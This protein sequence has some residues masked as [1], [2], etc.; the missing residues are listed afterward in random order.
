[1]REIGALVPRYLRSVSLIGRSLMR[2]N[3]KRIIG[4]AYRG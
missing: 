4:V 1:M 3:L 2:A